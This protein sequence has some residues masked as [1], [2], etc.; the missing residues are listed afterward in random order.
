MVRSCLMVLISK[1]KQSTI[2]QPLLISKNKI[3]NLVAPPQKGKFNGYEF[4]LVFSQEQFFACYIT[5][6]FLLA[7]HYQSS[8]SGGTKFFYVALLWGS[9]SFFT[10][11]N[12]STNN[13][14][15]PSRRHPNSHLIVPPTSV[16]VLVP[17]YIP[18]RLQQSSVDTIPFPQSVTPRFISIHGWLSLSRRACFRF[19][20]VQSRFENASLQMRRSMVNSALYKFQ[21]FQQG[22]VGGLPFSILLSDE[23]SVIFLGLILRMFKG[24]FLIALFFLSLH[25]AF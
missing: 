1:I 12:T 6:E 16:I 20:S 21:D 2:Y 14:F 8:F 22:S 18:L 19:L 25:F 9:F 24:W 11:K 10:Q 13:V 23:R 5:R 7:N 4:A 3:K 17:Q 15:C